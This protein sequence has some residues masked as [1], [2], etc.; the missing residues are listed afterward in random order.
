MRAPAALASALAL[1]LGACGAGQSAVPRATTHP[2]R[3]MSV[4]QCTD[5]LVLQLLPPERI[6]SVS[7]LSRDPAASV[8]A[9]AAERVGV[10]HGIAEEVLAQRPDLVIAGAFTT[11]ALRASL[12]RLGYPLVEV[13]DP[14]SIADI[15]RVTR[16]VAAAVGEPARGEALLAEM[17]AKLAALARDPA[18]PIRVVAWDKS[19]FGAGEGTLF[20]AVLRASGARNAGLEVRDRRPDVELLLK[21]APALLIQGTRDPR[22][23]DRGDDLALHRVVRKVWRGR[24]LTVPQSAYVCGTPRFADA[25]LALRDQLRTAARGAP[26][27]ALE[28]VRT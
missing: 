20:D 16:Q 8:M 12:R 10:N 6:A 25:A 23:A 14:Q 13:D 15:R 17:D 4:N 1:A 11:P 22:A 5:Q 21:T 2:L 3:V 7:W 18:P 27:P 19:G 26:R 9:A 28:D 24:M